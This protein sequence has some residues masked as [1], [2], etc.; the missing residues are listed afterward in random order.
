M[1]KDTI[2]RIAVIASIVFWAITAVYT[3]TIA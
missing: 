3:V 1:K 2:I